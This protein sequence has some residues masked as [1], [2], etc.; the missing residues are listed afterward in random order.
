M[1]GHGRLRD[2]RADQGARAHARRADHLRHRDLA[3][4]A[5]TS[6][7]ATRRARSTTSSSR[8]TRG[9]ALEGRGLPRAARDD[10]RAAPRARRCCARAFDERADRHGAAGRS[11][12]ASRGQPRARRAA[13]AAPAADLR[14]RLLDALVRRGR[15]R[16]DGE[17]REALVAGAPAATRPSC[18]LLGAGGERIPCALQLLAVARRRRA[19]TAL[20]VQ[21][22]DLRERQP[23]RGRARGAGP[24]AGARARRPSS[25]PS[26]C[27]AVQ[28]ITDAALG[29]LAFDELRQRAAASASSTS[30]GVD[31]RRDRAARRRRDGDRAPDGRGRAR[32]DAARRGRLPAQ[33]LRRRRARGR[34]ARDGATGRPRGHPLGDR[35]R[36]LLGV[37][38]RRRRAR[39]SA[40]C[41]SARCSRG[42]FSLDD[43]TACSLAADRAALAIAAHA[44]VRARAPDRRATL[45]RACCPTAL[46]LLPGVHDRGA[47]PARRRRAPRSA[48]TGTTRSPLPSGRAAARH[49]RRRRA[50]ASRPRRRWASCAARCAP[51]RCSTGDARR[52][53]WSALNRFQ[54]STGAATTWRRVAARRDRPGDGDARLRA[55]PATRRR[56]VVGA[57]RRGR[58]AS[59]AAAA[60]PLGRARRRRLHEATATL[61]PG[62][63]LL[64]LHRRAGRAARRAPRRGPRAPARPRRSPGPADLERAVRPRDR[65]GAAVLRHRRRRDAAGPAHASATA[66][67]RMDA[68]RWS[69]TSRR[70]ARS[71]GRCGAGWRRPARRPRSSHD[72][73]MA[74]NEAIQ[75]AIEH[76][77]RADAPAGRR[78][79]RAQRRRRRRWSSA[80]RAR[81]ASRASR[82][83]AG[84]GCRSCAR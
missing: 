19:A 53:C 76:G 33:R 28:R 61:E 83:T 84:A 6:S 49:R 36:S 35:G 5:S 48:A 24:R 41:T 64:A 59:T 7:A 81:G 42:A 27:A 58:A 73:T 12:G 66:R 32:R 56:C 52:R 74:A 25:S 43:A 45:Q 15:P 38:L 22:Q 14:G 57:R 60:S 54:C 70:C 69:A 55:R 16:R 2:R 77:A 72:V 18:V 40:R 39:R 29:S 75:N 34:R 44:A 37:P 13:R 67:E 17:R 23:G 11:T 9:P 4:S 10:A 1:P 82:S 50:A 3:R 68:R 46:P 65:H 47:L 51:T 31:T 20:I 26:G 21:V 78:G 8:T 30:L 63:T 79:A 71:A 80:T 62:S